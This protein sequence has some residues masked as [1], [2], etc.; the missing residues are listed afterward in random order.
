MRALWRCSGA[1]G[2][3]HPNGTGRLLAPPPAAHPQSRSSCA[4]GDV[5][6]LPCPP[7][8]AILPVLATNP[9]SRVPAQLRVGFLPANESSQ[10]RVHLFALFCRVSVRGSWRNPGRSRGDAIEG[11]GQWLGTK[12]Q[13]HQP[14]GL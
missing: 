11:G 5:L 9:A 3:E 12:D 7:C 8:P 1:V 6:P 10:L 14:Q 4:Q 13:P 2:R